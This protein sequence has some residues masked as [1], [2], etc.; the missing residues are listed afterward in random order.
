MKTQPD[1]CGCCGR[2]LAPPISNFSRE[3][4]EP[5]Q[6]HLGPPYE[7]PWDRTYIAQSGNSCPY[8]TKMPEVKR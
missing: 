2:E 8:Q 3:W 1:Y 6:R 4:C 7:S 5:C